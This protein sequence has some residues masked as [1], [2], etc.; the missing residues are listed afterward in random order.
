MNP[1]RTFLER[2]VCILALEFHDRAVL[3]AVTQDWF[4]DPIATRAWQAISRAQVAQTPLDLAELIGQLDPEDAAA[5]MEDVPLVI[6]QV[7]SVETATRMLALVVE[8]DR[9]RH[10]ATDAI[11]LAGSDVP[12][13][14]AL[15]LEAA[16]R[17][18]GIDAGVAPLTASDAVM[19]FYAD[20]EARRD[21][22]AP[23]PLLYGYP[24]MDGLTLGLD[25]GQLVLIA[26][27]AGIGKSLLAM[28]LTRQWCQA[29]KRVLY[30]SLEMS[31]KK[32]TARWC[33]MLSGLNSQFLERGTIQQTQ[34]WQALS[35]AIGQFG[36]WPLY[37]HAGGVM[38]L[39]EVVTMGRQLRTTAQID[40]V[41]V[42][43][44]GLIENP[45][46]NRNETQ[47]TQ[48][49]RLAKAMKNLATASGIP[50]IAL[51]QLNRES[52]HRNDNLPKLSDLRD[53]GDWEAHADVVWLLH[54][55]LD[56][57]RL[58]VILAKNRDG[59]PQ[60]MMEFYAD[61]E[62]M[63]ILPLETRRNVS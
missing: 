43:Y 8:R 21:G 9:L 63:R 24:A 35:L 45:P 23:P 10:A 32:C 54:R 2:A 7:N 40:A 29:G 58:T 33:A 18:M 26:A 60:R 6:D 3:S 48:V 4:L 12:A 42:D 47:A 14:R 59:K 17:P 39:P 36:A 51:V 53:S 56:D 52:E 44:A 62:H 34:H 31:A 50:V 55:E 13:A 46:L 30:V 28:N 5:L 20:V 19:A 25:A 22:T 49:G 11:R 15:L 57:E 37:L 61:L 1:S 41:V 38:S 16:T 27:R